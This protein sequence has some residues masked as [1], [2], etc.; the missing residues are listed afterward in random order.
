[1]TPKT[2]NTTQ[3]TVVK[4]RPHRRFEGEVVSVSGLKT[5]HVLVRAIKSHPIYKKQYSVS[6]KYAVHDEH[7]KAHV[8][9]NV[10]FEECRPISK[11]KRWT[12]VHVVTSVH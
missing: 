12:L 6:K 1:M 9:D 3:S 2:Q 7:G 10:L 8:G 11:T 4:Q 5:I